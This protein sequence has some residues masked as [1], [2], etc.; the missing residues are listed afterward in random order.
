LLLGGIERA[1]AAAVVAVRD[2]AAASASASQSVSGSGPLGNAAQPGGAS[3]PETVMQ[4][5]LPSSLPLVEVLH[6]DRRQLS[7]T[8]FRPSERL[9]RQAIERRESVAHVWT[10][11]Q[12]RSRGEFTVSEGLDWAFCTPVGGR[13]CAGWALYVTGSFAG[14]FQGQND[15][16]VER[17]RDEVKF[18][19]LTAATLS[20]LR[21]SRLLATRQASLSQFFSPVVLDAL[22]MRDADEALAPREADVT[23][24]F[25]D[26]RGF[27]QQSE[28]SA[29][30]LFDLLQR[31][32]QALGVMTHHILAQGGVVGDFHGDAAM[33]FW[34]WPIAQPDAVERACRAAQG[35]RAA[36]T[37]ASPTGSV[38][39]SSSKRAGF[40]W[41][42]SAATGPASVTG[43]ALVSGSQLAKDYLG[44][45]RV[46]IGIA[47]GRAVAG[48][49][50]TV[51]QVK[52]TVFGPVVNLASRLETMTK[53]LRAAILIDP[54]TAAVIRASVPQEI[55]G[56]RRLARVKPVGISTP[57]EVSELLPPL[58]TGE[59]KGEGGVLTCENI[60]TYEAALDAFQARDWAQALKHL[61]NVPPDDVAK[62]FLTMFIVQHGR[63]P[64]PNWDGS[65]PL[66]SK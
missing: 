41:V 33:G 55:C 46:G 9:I 14:E 34:G 56:V 44:R 66:E 35:I 51:D 21:E 43:S 29:G 57:L 3:V 7:G 38:M 49:I 47:S 2:D 63:T 37:G 4:P 12:T 42:G 64:P 52:V 53:Q 16:G 22:A 40:E 58:P 11:D 8:D 62:D 60:A 54:P 18:A 15:P 32:S 27:T 45:F 30:D 65:I 1:T 50:G 25:C 19:E 28:R 6:W 26:L 48:K 31:V 23:V 36:F 61:H 10:A 39:F 20:A 17:L 24:L 5:T 13:A 59:V